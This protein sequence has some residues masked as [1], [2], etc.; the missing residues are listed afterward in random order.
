MM[1]IVEDITTKYLKNTLNSVI[2]HLS[3]HVV[4]ERK[5]L[6]L[7]LQLSRQ[8]GHRDGL[9]GVAVPADETV[10]GR[11]EPGH[12]TQDVVDHLRTCLRLHLDL[13]LVPALVPGVQ[14]GQPL[15]VPAHADLVVRRTE[16]RRHVRLPRVVV[17]TPDPPH[18]VA[19]DVVAVRGQ[20][21][22]DQTKVLGT[23]KQQ[24]KTVVEASSTS[25][26]A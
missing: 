6:S 17:D 20:Q 3:V 10:V 23:F 12:I 19:P 18:R 15:V 4:L 16:G 11:G 21:T 8:R 9:T 2:E 1:I 14:R 7:Q 13:S 24:H 22:S 25:S 26:A 5:Q